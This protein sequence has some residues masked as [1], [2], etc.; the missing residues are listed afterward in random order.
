MVFHETKLA[1]AY[2]VDLEPRLDDRGFFARSWC[3]REFAQHGLNPVLVQCNVSYNKLAGTLRGMHFQVA[4]HAEVKLVRCTRGAIYDVMLDLRP[5]SPTFKQHV[6]FELTADNRRALYVPEGFGHGYL[7]LTNDTD[8]FYQVTA[9]YAPD[10]ASGV[11]WNDPAFGIV[12]PA[13]VRLISERDAQYPD[14]AG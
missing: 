7:T 4:P 10:A 1:G 11:R 3:Q 2:V 5:G 14:F 9:F 12:W 6:G 13:D 8:V